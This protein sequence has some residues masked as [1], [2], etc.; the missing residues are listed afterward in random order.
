MTPQSN[1][2]RKV[3]ASPVWMRYAD[4]FPHV[5]ARD[6]FTLSFYRELESSFQEIL[7]RGLGQPGERDHFIRSVPERKMPRYDA[8]ILVLDNEFSGPLK[9]FISR[10]WHDMLADVMGVNCTGDVQCALHHHR[11]GSASGWVHNDL[12]LKWFVDDPCRD[13]INLACC[14]RTP[15]PAKQ[16]GRQA[17]PVVRALTMLFYLNNQWTPGSGGDTGLYQSAQDL[18]SQP[19]AA[20]PPIDNSLLLFEC[21]PYS[22]HAFLQNPLYP[23]NSVNLWLHRT[24]DE[25]VARWGEHKI[26]DVARG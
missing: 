17:R 12:G 13:G 2:L 8:Y 5:V 11:I 24:K 15:D 7:A 6:T 4:P 1:S 16:A 25:V 22:F 18:P 19:A 23:R 26:F 14:G 9:M 10:Q 21:T 3:L 20:M